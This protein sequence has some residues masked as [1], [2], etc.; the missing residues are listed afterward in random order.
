[1][2]ETLHHALRVLIVFTAAALAAGPAE[3]AKAKGKARKA[4]VEAVSPTPAK[5]PAG[6]ALSP[7]GACS[8]CEGAVE[9]GRDGC[10]DTH[11]KCVKR[12]EGA[13]QK[14]LRDPRAL[15]CDSA[16]ESC[17]ATCDKAR[18]ACFTSKDK[19]YQECRSKEARKK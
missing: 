11:K 2:G 14:C 12:C 16:Q 10:G 19:A 3:A 4:P 9:K 17:G 5:C 18:S 15:D 1:M 13:Y 7:E 8:K 6:S